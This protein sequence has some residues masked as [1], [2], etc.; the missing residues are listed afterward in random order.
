ML[1][2]DTLDTLPLNLY[3]AEQIQQGELACAQK[4]GVDMY[5]LMEKAGH[6]VFDCL[7]AHFSNAHQIVVLAGNGNNGGDAYVVGRLA[8]QS[9]MP[10]LVFCDNPSLKLKGDAEIARQ[11]YLGS[12]GTLASFS[13]MKTLELSPDVVIDGLLGT[14]FKGGLR[15]SLADL[16]KYINNWHSPVISIDLPSG[17]NADSGFVDGE[18]LHADYTVTFVALK[19]GLFSMHGPDCVGKLLFAGLGI[20][21]EFSDSY[22]PVTRLLTKKSVDRLSQRP[23]NSNKGNFGHVVCF[24]G[25]KGMAGAIFLAAKAALRSGAGKVSV[26]THP[27]NVVII[28]T[29]CPELM[30]FGFVQD[31]NQHLLQNKLTNSD[32][33]ILGPGLGKSDWGRALFAFVTA[34]QKQSHNPLV[35]DADG[36]NLLSENFEMSGF[37]I[38]DKLN[39]VVTPHPLEA[40]RLLSCSVLNINQYR[41]N[42][43]KKISE[44]YNSICVLKGS[45]TLIHSSGVC[46]I[47]SSGNPGMASA[48]MGDVLAGVIAGIIASR[49]TNVNNLQLNVEL[50]VFLHGLAGDYAAIDGEI[51]IIA[52]DLIASLPKAINECY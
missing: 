45:G 42:S 22:K 39:W 16:I 6:A 13:E 32:C 11:S 4:L 52:T 14:G 7:L 18:C 35:L 37:P 49:K 17:L 28:T 25:D 51:G 41:L 46:A 33:L 1:F 24:G 34:C 19:L 36:L 8:K 20:D 29:L 23:T 27:D 31:D 21:S 12:G 26:F 44:R 5:Q 30:V 47:N 43:A 50:A 15:P 9:D 38:H 48:G 3:L 2:K 40:A 10:V